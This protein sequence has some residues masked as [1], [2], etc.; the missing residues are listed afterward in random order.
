[1]K[2]GEGPEYRKKRGRKQIVEDEE[3][4][5]R[6]AEVVVRRIE[7]M[8]IKRGLVVSEETLRWV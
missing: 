4:Q 8:G 5:E 3:E 2:V 1:M 7:E 6:E